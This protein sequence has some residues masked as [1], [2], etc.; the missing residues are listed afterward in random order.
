MITLIPTQV[1]PELLLALLSTA[2]TALHS[3]AATPAQ[4]K[5]YVEGELLVKFRGGPK[6]ADAKRAK[7][8]LKHEVKRDFD[9]IGW[10]HI[11]LPKGMTVEE[12]L[13]EYRKMPNV[14]AVEPNGLMEIEDPIPQPPGAVEVLPGQGSDAASTEQTLFI[15]AAVGS[16]PNDPQFPTQWNLRLLGMTKAWAVSTGSRDVVIAVLDSG[17][18]YTHEDLRD[19]MWRNPG[20]TG[21]DDLGRDKATN[22]VDDDGNGYIDDVYGIDVVD[23]D[24]DPMDRGN[25]ALFHGTGCAG[26]IGATGNNGLGIA[27]VNWAVRLMAIRIIDTNNATSAAAHLEGVEYVLEMKRRGVNI[28]A[29][30]HSYGGATSFN[31]VHYDA[32]LQLQEAGIL[33]VYGAGNSAMDM[34]RLSHTPATL[35]LPLFLNVAAT[36][37]SD[38]LASYA[39]FGRSTVDLGAPGSFP[40][41]TQPTNHYT[42]PFVGASFAAPHVTGAAGLLAAVKPDATAW[43]IRGA[44]MQSVDQKPGLTNKVVTHGRLNVGRAVEVLTNDSLP[45]IVVA[46][47]PTSSRTRQSQRLEVWFSQPMNRASVESA[48]E[49]SPSVAGTFLW[50]DDSRSFHLVRSD[51]FTWTN[52]TAISAARP[53]RQPV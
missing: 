9:F 30:N 45:P 28:R 50:S 12:A 24:S 4:S 2:L 17:I 1:R 52:H 34:D 27:G 40:P 41:M 48:F 25:N 36:D 14:L 13:P 53:C 7:A 19:N 44:L 5:R 46:V 39:D 47:T 33:Q 43:E 16:T 31:P 3:S 6:G 18:D 21:V 22:G 49:I 10:Q 15:A 11:R 8:S 20:E 37:S 32:G 26:I 29:S 38:G 23:G 42:S 51:L 35:D